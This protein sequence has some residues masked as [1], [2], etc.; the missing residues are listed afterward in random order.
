MPTTFAELET[1]ASD[2]V[3]R[4]VAD[5]AVLTAACANSSAAMRYSTFSS[6]AGRRAGHR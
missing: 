1:D 4:A 2:E 6:N 5:T 3:L